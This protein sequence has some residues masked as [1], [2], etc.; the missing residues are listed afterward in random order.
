MRVQEASGSAKDLRANSLRV[1]ALTQDIPRLDRCSQM[2][3]LGSQ[4]KRN[5]GP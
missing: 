4:H 2:G 1:P 3:S 5:I